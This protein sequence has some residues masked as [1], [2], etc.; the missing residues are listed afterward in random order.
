MNTPAAWPPAADILADMRRPQPLHEAARHETL[1]PETWDGAAVRTRMAHIAT[2][3]QAEVQA[4]PHAPHPATH[5]RDEDGP[6]P[7]DGYKGSYLGGAGLWW[8]LHR[9]HG[10]G[11][12]PAVPDITTVMDRVAAGYRAAPDTGE[13]VPSLFLGEV[14]VELLRWHATGATDAFDALEALVRGNAENPTREGLWGAPGTMWAA[15]HLAQATGQARWVDTWLHSARALMA[16][17][18][19]H[20]DAGC[21]LWL[22]DMYGKTVHYLGAGHGAVG[23]VHALLAG[24]AWLEPAE[25]ELLLHRTAQLLSATACRVDGAANWAPGLYPPRPGTARF[26]MQWCH[27]APGF[28]TALAGV[29]PMG[30]DAR[31]DTLLLEA[32]ESIW[33]AGPL[34]KGGGLCHGT[35]GNGWALLMLHRRT[36]DARWLQRARAMA[37]HALAQSEAMHAEFGRWRPTLWTGDP[38]VLLF[39]AQCLDGAEP[40][41][42]LPGLDGL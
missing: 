28:V 42:G 23:N 6:G 26:L 33:R 37:L 5:P 35:A 21:H 8:A 11:L 12:A 13:R 41:R 1:R 16:T 36:G 17:W 4:G 29:Y 40:L 25:R 22:Q 24:M 2:A 34:T 31:V 14:G 18:Q 10:W 3:L 15:W 27:G 38:G 20:A 7:A 30:R 9:L 32:G 39:A 19:W